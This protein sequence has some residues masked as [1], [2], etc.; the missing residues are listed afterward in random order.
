MLYAKTGI[1]MMTGVP[2][3]KSMVQLHSR[4]LASSV[5]L[6][7][8]AVLACSLLTSVTPL[9]ATHS[10]F[11]TAF[12]PAV[13]ASAW[14]GGAVFGLIATA[15]S[16]AFMIYFVLG[17]IHSFAINATEDFARVRAFVVVGICISLGVTL[18]RRIRDAALENAERLHTTLES[19]GDAVTVTDV[20]GSITMMNAVA[21]RL[22][23]WPAADAI[24]HPLR[25]VFHIIHEKSRKDVT[26]LLDA[27][28]NPLIIN[29]PDRSVL[30]SRDGAEHPIEASVSLIREGT[31]VYGVVLVFRDVSIQRQ[32]QREIEDAARQHQE[33]ARQ[34]E[35]LL[36][37]ERAALAQAEA[38]NQMKDEFFAM[39]SHE[40]RTPLTAILGW[41]P[42][43][44]KEQ[45]GP[46]TMR[47]GLSSIQRNAKLQLKL[48]EDLLDVSRITTGALHLERRLADINTVIA[49]AIDTVRVGVEEK[50]ISL[51]FKPMQCPLVYL[52]PI[53]CQQVFCNLLSNAIKFTP[54]GGHIRVN[55]I[56]GG[57]T[58]QVQVA[59]DGLGFSPDFEPRLFE[60]FQQADRKT[61][62]HGLGL[63]LS[64][65]RHI[66]ELHDGTV[67]GH[68][69]GLHKG[70][71]F[72]VNL[73]TKTTATLPNEYL[74]DVQTA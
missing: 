12:I 63:G 69:R 68:S 2:G 33:I 17:P 19:I 50:K 13:L 73:P 36:K 16:S 10:I 59:D 70:A 51:T 18:Q 65:V 71:T 42:L 60:R 54:Q 5:L 23:A 52:D 48:V 20:S 61:S 39:V 46:D 1:K 34:R 14:Y 22:T 4:S 9:H 55:V 25:T 49:S 6:A 29:M 53:R 58:L 45:V 11:A 47:M 40:L 67:E 15:L 66:V 62:R 38:T 24:G 41:T 32:H 7:V 43:I 72:V 57:E 3:S 37:R 8:T 27:E 74:N 21:E 56:S 30:V 26:G 31:R 44:L 28:R 64:I 35:L